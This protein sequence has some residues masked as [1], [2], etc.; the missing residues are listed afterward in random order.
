MAF[1]VGVAPAGATTLRRVDLSSTTGLVALAAAA[2]AGIA[3]VLALGL[4]VIVRR[5]RAAQSLVLGGSE[6]DLVAHA[7]ELTKAFGDLRAYVEEASLRLDGRLKTAEDRIDGV[8][9]YRGLLRYDAY[10][11]LSGR[12]ST[13]IALLDTTRSGIVI[14]S[15]HHRDQARM[16]TKIV[17]DGVGEIP[18]SPEETE[19][20]RMA[21]AREVQEHPAS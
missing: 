19:A 20:V 6:R 11:E 14:S 4:A 10:N 17:R 3:L 15:I 9:A 12:Q 16:Y 18:L 2:A 1:T 13:S 8:I 5:L 21:L 7:A